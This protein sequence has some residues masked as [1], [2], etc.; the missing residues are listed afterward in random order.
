MEHKAIVQ[1]LES[2]LNRFC[3]DVT[4]ETEY[5]LNSGQCGE[6]DLIGHHNYDYFAI[7]VKRTDNS[8]NRHKAM[9][10]L[11][12]DFKYIKE[13]YS[14]EKIILLYA[15]SSRNGYNIEMIRK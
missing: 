10:Q 3:E 4:T 8:T 12:R 6:Y 14:P 5:V 2:R 11:D 1:D 7:E 9:K 15:Y 13:N